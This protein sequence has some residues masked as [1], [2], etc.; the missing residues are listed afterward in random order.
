MAQTIQPIYY[1]Y[2]HIK[3]TDGTPFYVGKGKDRRALSKKRSNWWKRVVNKYGYD[4]IF[5]EIKLTEQEATERE[6]YWIKRIG[7]KDLGLGP[8]V[9]MTD[10]GEGTSGIIKISQPQTPET[11]LK[12]S[13][14]NKG[15]IAWN[16]GKSHS[17]IKGSKH[18][19]SKK[20]INTKTGEI[21]DT[22]LDAAKA[23]GI[24][25]STLSAKLSGQNTNK[26]DLKFL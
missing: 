13:L 23:I 22:I 26:T 15:K 19:D 1:V 24:K 25:R 2:L 6:K 10:G 12:I 7:R 17:A 18:Y 9:N 4:I 11:K 3:L 16:K 20:V 21:Y 8:L 5:L 14:A